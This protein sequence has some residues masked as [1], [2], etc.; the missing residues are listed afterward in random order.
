MRR[1]FTLVAALLLAAMPARGQDMIDLNAVAVHDSAP[2][3]AGWAQTVRI[4][5]LTMTPGQYGGISIETSPAMPNSWVVQAFPL[6][7]PDKLVCAPIPQ[8]TD[9][10]LQYTV[11][12]FAKVNGAWHG[13]GFIQMWYGRPST[14]APMLTDFHT[15]WAYACDRWGALCQYIPQVGDTMAFM[16]SAGN[17]R[18]F[19][20]VS[21]VRER[22]NVVTV[23]LPAGDN[24]VF[25]FQGGPPPPPQ[26]CQ[27]PRATNVGGP[28]PCQYPTPPPPPSVDYGPRIAQ[29]EAQVAAVVTRIT[30]AEGRLQVAESRLSVLEARPV[31]TSCSAS[32][33]LGFARIPVSC[34]V[35]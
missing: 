6:D 29:L 1:I 20:A 19:T 21:S 4:T 3:I 33:N 30:S 7:H 12:A 2:D 34:S 15:N 14:G 13:A 24:G 31:V 9:G 8:V 11:W 17:A 5:K 23:T 22:S 25:E 28:L 32:A 18:D 16:V 10:C 35:K 27:D 26:T